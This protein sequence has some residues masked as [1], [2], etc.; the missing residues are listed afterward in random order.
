MPKPSPKFKFGDWSPDLAELDNPGVIEAANVVWS[1]GAYR[2]YLPLLPTSAPIGG[3]QALACYRSSFAGIA[4][5]GNLFVAYTNGSSQTLWAQASSGF[6][7]SDITPAINAPLGVFSA[8][9]DRACFI[10]YATDVGSYLIATYGSDARSQ[11][12]L[13][14]PT[15][16]APT[17]LLPLTGSDGYAPEALYCGIIGQFVVLANQP[18]TPNFSVSAVQWSGIDAPLNWPVPNSAQ[19]IAEQSGSQI[20]DSRLGAANGVAGADQWGVVL[21]EGGLVRMTYTGGSTVF[22]FDTIYRGPGNL[23]NTGWVKIGGIIFFLST[24]GIF[25][26]DGSQ[27]TNIGDSRINNWLRSNADFGFP[28]NFQAGV[29]YRQKII[30]W[31]FPLIGNSGVPNAWLAYNYQENK[32]SH[33]SDSI[34]CYF[35]GNEPYSTL[36][37]MQAF[38]T[39][40]ACGSFNGAPGTA[41]LT[42]PEIELNPGGKALVSGVLPQVSGSSPA[43]SV[44][45][46]SR[47]SQGDAVTF[48]S[49]QTPDA[50]T[51]SAN[52]LVDQRYH[53]AQISIVGAF[54]K[55]IGGEFDASP[56]SPL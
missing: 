28:L 32:F 23:A 47:N 27:A 16:V 3:G 40:H 34:A 45:L 43:V 36:Y 19:A 6:T 46:G 37:G 20:I 51:Q 13:F 9:A 44:Q 38:G 50:F 8:P 33:G 35:G 14:T 1:G 18:T 29:D 11:A 4:S 54:D 25:M 2:P 5:P 39:L 31:S 49:A 42:S 15:H 30:Y 53:R 41:I 24:V 56:T 55:A 22:Q 17:P 12:P 10:Q 26:T 52:F 48:S 21:M 7:F